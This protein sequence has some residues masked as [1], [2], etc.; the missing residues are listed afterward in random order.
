MAEARAITTL[1]APSEALDEQQRMKKKKSNPMLIAATVIYVLLIVGLIYYLHSRNYES[2]DDAQVDGHIAAVAARVDGTVDHI[3][4]D[5]GI[6]VRPGQPLLDLDRTDNKVA[7]ANATAKYEQAQAGVSAQNPNLPITLSNNVTNISAQEAAVA[8]ARAALSAAQH[9][10]GTALAMLAQAQAKNNQSQADYQRYQFL[11]SKGEAARSDYDNYG[12]TAA[13]QKAAV[14]ADE[15]SVASARKTIEQREADLAKQQAQLAQLQQ[16]APRQIAIQKASL[17][18]QRTNATSLASQVEQANLNL[19]Y[20]HVVAPVFGVIM[21]RSAEIGN[22][23]SAG[24]Q[25]MMIV[26]IDDLWV[27][28]N[29]KET[30]LTHMH[31]G[32]HVTI[33]VDALNKDL[34]G[35]VERMPAATG[36]I[37]SVLPP[38]NATGNYVKVVQRMPVRLRFDAGQADLSRLRP[39]MSVEPTVRVD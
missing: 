39:G 7:V 30:Q 27:T 31:P 10:L 15:E 23:I 32:Q 2:T 24:Q 35:T 4:V 33:H 12:A 11:F 1:T 5:E 26:Q 18:I 36:S 9:E 37:T 6:Y 25:L 28:A 17:E 8:N 34:A 3:Y 19:Q 14:E 20:C 38:E 16:N 22:R 21:Q 29:F 13:A